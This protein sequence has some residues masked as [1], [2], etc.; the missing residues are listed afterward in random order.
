MK[1]IFVLLSLLALVAT[2][3]AQYTK[4]YQF[5]KLVANGTSAYSTGQTVGNTDSLDFRPNGEASSIQTLGTWVFLQSCAMT[6][7]IKND[8]RIDWVIFNDRPAATTDG[9]AWT[10]SY[11]DLKKIVAV[12]PLGNTYYD[13]TYN[14]FNDEPQINRMLIAPN[15]G[16]YWYV[17]VIRATKTWTVASTLRLRPLF[18]K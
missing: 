9:G 3:Q 10:P 1:R 11:A 17:L 14:S 4:A 2:A 8:A 7:S 16:K 13:G 18:F 15:K 5:D 12:I 6:D